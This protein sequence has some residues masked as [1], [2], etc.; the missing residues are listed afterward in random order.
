C[1]T[2][3]YHYYITLVQQTINHYCCNCTTTD[4]HY[5]TTFST[6]EYHYCCNVLQRTIT[7]ILLLVQQPS[8]LL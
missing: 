3:D 2:T 8:L 4:Y 5:Y 7:I 6:A 1:T